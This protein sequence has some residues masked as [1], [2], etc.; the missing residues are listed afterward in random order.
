VVCIGAMTGVFCQ[1]FI[2]AEGSAA[3]CVRLEVDGFVVEEL[4]LSL[5]LA[6]GRVC[7]HGT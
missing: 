1:R 6:A 7:R 5:W 3:L 2:G 4:K